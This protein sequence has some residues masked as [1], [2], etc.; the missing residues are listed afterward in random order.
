MDWLVQLILKSAVF[1]SE[2][3]VPPKA[4]VP[5]RIVGAGARSDGSACDLTETPS[6]R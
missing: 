3:N 4:E 2:M 1:R 6:A 5:I